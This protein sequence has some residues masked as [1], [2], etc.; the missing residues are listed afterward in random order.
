MKAPSQRY[1]IN[2]L[3]FI[4]LLI[5]IG[6]NIVAYQQIQR[7]SIVN[8]WVI[9]THR[10][11]ST[12]ENAQLALLESSSVLDLAILSNRPISSA[13]LAPYFKRAEQNIDL[14]RDLTIDNPFQQQRI[15]ELQTTLQKR[16]D[17]SERIVQ[18]YATDKTL[19]LKMDTS[20]ELQ[21]LKIKTKNLFTNIIQEEQ[22]LL[23]ERNDFYQ[24][25]I[26]NT[27]RI[28][29]FAM[30]SSGLLFILS[31]FLL[32]SYLNQLTETERIKSEA[33]KRLRLIINGTYDYAIMMLDTEGKINTWNTG[34]ERIYGYIADEIV[35]QPFSKFLSEEGSKAYRPSNELDIANKA[36]RFEE[37][38]WHV[39]K[40]GSRFFANVVITAL[41]DSN[42]NLIGFVN[43][44]R[45]LSERIKI[46]KIK[47]EFVSVVS[48]E[49]RTPITSIRGALGLILGG[50]VGEFS[51]KSKKLLDIA[52][53]NCE[54]LL[55]LINDILDIEKIEEGKMVFQ[56]NFFDIEKIVLESINANKIYAEKF[57]I[58]LDLVKTVSNCI[59]NVDA[60]RLMQVLS[61]LF[62]N[63]VK[64]SAK[65]GYVDVEISEVNNFVRVSVTNRGQGIPLEFQAQIFQKFS[66]ADTSN[67]RE[68][69][70]TGL[71]LSI[72]KAIIE[73]MHGIL[74][75]RSLPS[76][77]TTFYF[78]LPRRINFAVGEKT[79]SDKNSLEKLDEK[80]LI[81]EDDEDQA[82]YLRA[83]LEAGGFECD[84]ACT[85]AET[86]KLL[87]MHSYKALLL[88][89]ILPDQ[90][91]ISL[92]RELRSKE[93]T[94]TLP[95]IVQSV[96]S[97]T[98]RN[99]LNGEAFSVHDWL[100]KPINFN[101]LIQS[102]GLIKIKTYPNIPHILHIED[103]VNTQRI[104]AALLDQH[105]VISVAASLEETKKALTEGKYDLVILDLLLPDGN[106][107]ELLP[108]LSKYRIPIIVNSSI[109]L[110]MDYAKYVTQILMK[111]S[112]STE[113]LIASIK[114]YIQMDAH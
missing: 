93:R 99:L 37:E 54:R 100:D 38:C 80:I 106:G 89:L 113:E 86:K 12:A 41:Y 34:A 102:I 16:M 60:D 31:L 19:A 104:I 20:E 72:S 51:E 7:V 45:D 85:A 29:L 28:F 47:K 74:N 10:A 63:A 82:N 108:L 112:T 103:D 6:S 62:S 109:Q 105:A 91:G 18:L 97:E 27:N 57:G 3:F 23:K 48:H 98:G 69:G 61:N 44:S 5:L 88:D 2:I 78:D 75:F 71:G 11:I 107:A 35:G 79:I 21:L 70:G 73:K 52:N 87:G 39:R 4:G 1:S 58:K 56:F 65:D 92:I 64:F 77:E 81:C 83:L 76:G 8:E 101:K 14:L 43:F 114:K 90:D 32:S 95:I 111:S 40:D 67:T 22:Y 25:N 15:F 13:Q 94:R 42:N 84:V 24:H 30:A 68:K 110:D 33:E 46:A 26:Q 55:L 49:L 66:Q 36:G 53:Q 17:S 9:H 50:S 96:I 59:V